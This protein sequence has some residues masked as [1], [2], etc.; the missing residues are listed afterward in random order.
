MNS[1]ERKKKGYMHELCN[2][3]GIRS[4][5]TC[6]ERGKLSSCESKVGVEP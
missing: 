2:L 3:N 5:F 4:E 1:S 6:E